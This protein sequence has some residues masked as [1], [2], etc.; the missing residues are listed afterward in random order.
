[1]NQKMQA[2]YNMLLDQT[3]YNPITTFWSDFTIA[4]AFGK[5]A[6]IDTFHRAFEEWKSNYKY[7]TEL[8]MV[9]NWKIWA[10][11]ELD[12]ESEFAE[13]YNNLWEKADSYAAN[14]LKGEEST[15]FFQTTD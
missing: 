2:Y 4:E 14:N 15:Y 1:M 12:E 8:V 13:V 11:N 6:V 5:K 10:W 3:G 9:L 7:L